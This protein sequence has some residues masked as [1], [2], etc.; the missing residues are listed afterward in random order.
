LAQN[1]WRDREWGP[2]REHYGEG[3]GNVTYLQERELMGRIETNSIGK[4]L[5]YGDA[6]FKIDVLRFHKAPPQ[7]F[8]R[9]LI[10]EIARRL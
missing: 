3:H 7:I 1:L 10:R 4:G 5:F 2:I 8:E 9:G 6:E